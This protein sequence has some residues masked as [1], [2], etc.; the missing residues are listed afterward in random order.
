[1]KTKR[2]VTKAFGWDLPPK[3]WP[4]SGPYESDDPDSPYYRPK[5]DPWKGLTPEEAYRRGYEAG[6]EHEK[7]QERLRDEF[8]HPEHRPRM[9]LDPEFD[10][11]K[12][13]GKPRG[14]R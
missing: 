9:R 3:S 13:D 5:T 2:K 7:D 12:F 14:S 6:V 8:D 10:D 1:M 11:R 4:S